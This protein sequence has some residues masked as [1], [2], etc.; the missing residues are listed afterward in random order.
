MLMESRTL[1][2]DA[3]KKVGERVLIKGWVS[4]VRDHGKLLFLDVRDFTGVVQVVLSTANSQLSNVTMRDWFVVRVEGIVKERPRH[5]RNPKLSTGNIEIEASS[6][7]IFSEAKPLPFPIDTDGYEIAED[8]RLKYRYLDLRRERNQENLRVRGEVQDIVRHFLKERGFAEVETPYLT[9]STPEGARDFLVPSR[10]DPGK[11]YALPQ[12]PQQYKQLLMLSGIER[13][14]QFPRC[15]RD[16]DL[17]GDRLLEFTQ[18][19]IEMAFTNQEEVLQLTEEFVTLVTEKLGRK[20]QEK[21]FPRLTFKEAQEKFHTDKP[22]LRKERKDLNSMAYVWITDFPMFEEK[23]DGS[24][25]VTHHPFTAVE[26]KWRSKIS[27]KMSRREL[28]GINAQQYDLALNG[29]EIFGGSIREYKGENLSRIFEVLGY[30]RKRIER[31]FGHLLEAFT[32]GVPPHGGIAGGFDRWIEVLMG[33]SSIREVV[34]FPTSGSG[35]AAV[36]ESPSPVEKEQLEP[37]AISLTKAKK[38]K[39]FKPR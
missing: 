9:K 19:D 28:L 4:S 10:L 26:E 36:M 37:L 17:R 14:F 24:L 38:L 22:D 31:D 16:E 8:L 5:L 20:I 1:I 7:G 21:P 32:Y 35:K 13:Y 23:D 3:G 34:A 25:G 6:I 12:S 27:P 15:F 2:R 30:E 33:E 18:L 39:P 11:F 29:Y